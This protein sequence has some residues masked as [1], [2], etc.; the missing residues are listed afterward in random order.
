M[1]NGATAAWTVV[2]PV[3]R[4]PVAKTR[5]DL[6]AVDRKSLAL[7]MAVDTVGAA[8]ASRLVERVLVI[9]DD[10]DATAAVVAAGAEVVPDQPNS[11]LNAALEF[12]LDFAVREGAGAVATLSADLPA[13]RPESLSLLARIDDVAVVGDAAGSGT[14]LLGMR[15]G[16]RLPLSFGP[17]SRERHVEHGAADLTGA[18][19]PR[20][21]LD[22]DTVGDLLRAV[23]LGVG[24]ATVAVVSG[25]GLADLRVGG[26]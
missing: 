18:A 5:V 9:T 24:P 25:L 22:V 6:P 8:L 16:H 17:G 2:L 7:A 26:R 4:L 20:L 21:R 1:S 15:G 3:K 14:T 19:D 13:L 12:G 23:D 11:G 10:E